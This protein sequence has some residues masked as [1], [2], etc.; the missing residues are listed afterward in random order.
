M[1][2]AGKSYWENF[3]TSG[4]KLEITFNP[5]RRNF[6]D[7]HRLF[8]RHLPKEAGLRFLEV[9]CWPGRFMWYFERYFGYE[10]SGLDYLES[11]CRQTEQ[12]MAAAGVAAR[13]IC[14]DLFTYVPNT[15]ER[16]D[17]VASFGL[18]EHFSDSAEVISRHAQLARPGGYVAIVIPNLQG[19]YG[20]ILKHTDSEAFRAHQV[21]SL[22]E[23][24]AASAQVTGIRLLEAGYYGR[25]GFG[26]TGIRELAA[27]YGRVAGFAVRAFLF[28]VESLG[29]LLP[30]SRRLS[31][32]IALLARREGA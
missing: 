4:G 8:E 17:V 12:F 15:D 21:I 23:L 32:S 10:V 5:R 13:V 16:W 29:Q 14:A 31:P 24:K 25:L 9:G 1:D 28:V 6:S 20:W 26:H 19:L 22:D 11:S 3:Q 30:R 27:R 18:V 7:L 2:L